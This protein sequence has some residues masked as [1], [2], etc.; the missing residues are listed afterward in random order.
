MPRMHSQLNLFAKCN[1][2]DDGAV[3]AHQECTVNQS[4]SREITM[5]R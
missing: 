4:L 2:A 1:D 5:R 3:I